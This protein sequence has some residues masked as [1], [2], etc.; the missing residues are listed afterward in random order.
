MI[1]CCMRPN[2]GE[3]GKFL[4]GPDYRL[5]ASPDIRAIGV[6]RQLY[7]IRFVPRSREWIGY[8]LESAFVTKIFPTSACMLSMI[9]NIDILG[10][11]VTPTNEHVIST[12]DIFEFRATKKIISKLLNAPGLDVIKAN[13]QEVYYSHRKTHYEIQG[14]EG[15]SDDDDYQEEEYRVLVECVLGDHS[16]MSGRRLS[17]VHV[18]HSFNG[19]L[20]ALAVKQDNRR[21]VFQLSKVIASTSS[22]RRKKEFHGLRNEHDVI[23]GRGDVVLMIVSGKFLSANQEDF[24]YCSVVEEYGKPWAVSPSSTKHA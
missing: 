23:L 5:W 15:G 2:R 7:D 14:P 19:V 22:L 12:C 21:A 8:T 6:D 9:R 11:S 18:W 20:I 13:T 3:F 4:Q 1:L 24:L 16:P 10:Q 17:E